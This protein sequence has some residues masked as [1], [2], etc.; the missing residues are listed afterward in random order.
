MKRPGFLAG[1]YALTPTAHRRQRAKNR[2]RFGAFGKGMMLPPPG[3]P[4]T[5]SSGQPYNQDPNC[6]AG[7][8]VIGTEPCESF[9]PNDPCDPGELDFI[10]AP[11]PNYRA[12]STASSGGVRRLLP[13]GDGHYMEVAGGI[14]VGPKYPATFPVHQPPSNLIGPGYNCQADGTG[15]IRCEPVQTV[16]VVAPPTAAQAAFTPTIIPQQVTGPTSDDLQAELMALSQEAAK[17][18]AIVTTIPQ[19]APPSAYTGS[20]PPSYA[21][22]RT[23][24]GPTEQE[25]LQELV[26]KYKTDKPVSRPMR[27]VSS[28]VPQT[29]PVTTAPLDIFGWIR[30]TLFGTNSGMEG[31]SDG[32]SGNLPIIAV[33][34]IIILWR[35]Q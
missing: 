10:C 30:S 29:Q 18:E 16:T 24:T 25:R 27:I 12:Q 8:K 31:W 17:T 21:P 20:P 33:I 14:P 23:K 7:Q 6:P 13:T 19:L 2:S 15:G 11:D 9:D 22:R 32:L 35:Y 4:A 1:C 34:I 26:A 3:P 28:P 5:D